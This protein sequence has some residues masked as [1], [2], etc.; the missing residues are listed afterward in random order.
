MRR[1]KRYLERRLEKDLEPEPLLAIKWERESRFARSSYN[2]VLYSS[3]PLTA[4]VSSQPL[5]RVAAALQEQCSIVIATHETYSRCRIYSLC[6][7]FGIALKSFAM[8]GISDVEQQ[9]CQLIVTFGEKTDALSAP[10]LAF[11]QDGR[12]LLSVMDDLVERG[13]GG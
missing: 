8:R 1:W 4:D 6:R 3:K 11:E 9:S 2:V 13:H 5:L 10:H 12:E 7:E